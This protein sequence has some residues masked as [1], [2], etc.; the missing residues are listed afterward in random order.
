MLTK[1]T[2]LVSE[3]NI[4]VENRTD[5]YFDL[6]QIVRLVNF[7]RQQMGLPIGIAIDVTF[8]DESIMTDLHVRHMGLPG[9]T[10]VLSFP[11]L[12][13][14]NGPINPETLQHEPTL[15]EILIC[16]TF[17]GINAQQSNRTHALNFFLLHG[18]LH[19]LG[20]RHDDRFSSDVMNDLAASLYSFWHNGHLSSTQKFTKMSVSQ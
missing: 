17:I 10:D 3:A 14:L 5:I 2:S 1:V 18:L 4:T 8:V 15:G 16:P 19:L 20:Y 7:C 6:N 12:D 11:A 13:A 9:P